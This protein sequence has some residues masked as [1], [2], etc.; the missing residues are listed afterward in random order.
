MAELQRLM[1]KCKFGNHLEEALRDQLVCGI[2]NG[3]IQ[4]RLLA[5]ED[6]TLEK[7]F[8]IA[9]GMETAETNSMNLQ[10]CLGQP[11]CT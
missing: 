6:L 11:S 3:H 10:S 7:V 9:Q 2:Q 4:R 5:I 8:E 1:D